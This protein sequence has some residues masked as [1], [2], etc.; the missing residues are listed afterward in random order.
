MKNTENI[1]HDISVK[2]G[3][4][5][6]KTYSSLA[7]SLFFTGTKCWS[8]NWTSA[9]LTI[10]TVLESLICGICLTIA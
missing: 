9:H 7:D 2:Y 3:P 1:N 6:K 4:N 8:N 5:C 10:T